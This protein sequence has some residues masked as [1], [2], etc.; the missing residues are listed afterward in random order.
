MPR[1]NVELDG[2]WAC[3]SGISDEFITPF[4]TLEE[5][6]KWRDEEYGRQKIAL[7]ETNRMTFSEAVWNM[8]FYRDDDGIG[9]NLKYALGLTEESEENE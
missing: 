7:K 2:K 5:F 1:F 8:C 9:E 3:Y 6:E 4:M